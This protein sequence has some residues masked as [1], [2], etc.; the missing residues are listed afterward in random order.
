MKTIENVSI[1]DYQVHRTLVLRVQ[2]VA[3]R[4][5]DTHQA[6]VSFAAAC[7]GPAQAPLTSHRQ[8]LGGV[9]SL[10]SFPS[11]FGL[12]VSFSVRPHADL[13]LVSLRF[14]YPTAI[15]HV[16]Y[17]VPGMILYDLEDSLLVIRCSRA[18]YAMN[19]A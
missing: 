9:A 5:I 7:S 12:V 18:I 15:L 19:H 8:I 17:L 4:T 3:L 14:Q 10:S 16:A 6:P 2:R 13:S 1:N 11:L